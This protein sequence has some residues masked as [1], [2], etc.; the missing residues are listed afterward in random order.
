MPEAIDPKF[1]SGKWQ[2]SPHSDFYFGECPNCGEVA[3]HVD[4][5][6]S[7]ASE[8]HHEAWFECECGAR[9]YYITTTAFRFGGIDPD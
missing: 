7:H 9:F 1:E 5:N 8:F 2:F 3:D 4:D 6:P